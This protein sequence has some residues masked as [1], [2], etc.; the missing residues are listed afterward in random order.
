MSQSPKE[1]ISQSAI[2]S[3][4][5]ASGRPDRKP[6]LPGPIARS[7][8]AS[9]LQGSGS[10][11][12][13]SIPTVELGGKKS[14]LDSYKSLGPNARIIFGLVVGAVGIAGLMIDGNVLQDDTADQDKSGISV[15]MVDRK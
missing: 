3:R 7:A 9:A 14:L 13:K 10:V 5:T 8:R 4:A 6:I 11:S 12:P 1:T 2:T 15:R